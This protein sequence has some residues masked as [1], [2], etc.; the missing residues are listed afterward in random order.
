MGF[1]DKIK[2]G[3]TK[4]REALSHT[5]GSVFYGFSQLDSDFYD[6][7][8]EN[9]ILVNKKEVQSGDSIRVAQI[10]TDH[11]ALGYTQE[12]VCP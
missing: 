1:F 7:L 10:G 2:A 11:Y 4:T 5:L 12:Y 8:E 9:L 6:E 3:L